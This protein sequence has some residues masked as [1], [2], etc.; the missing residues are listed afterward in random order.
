MILGLQTPC[1]VLF[2]FHSSKLNLVIICVYFMQKYH[3]LYI[4]EYQNRILNLFEILNSNL[5]G[6]LYSILL[7][8]RFPSRRIKIKAKTFSDFFANP[9]KFETLKSVLEREEAS[10]FIQKPS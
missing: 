8:D 3:C 5:F 1:T 4:F 6:L 7:K 2:I 9:F 10:N